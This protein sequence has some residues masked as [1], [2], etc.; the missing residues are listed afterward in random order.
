MPL[1]QK[2]DPGGW[3]TNPTPPATGVV[4]PPV[5]TARNE[6][7]RAPAVAATGNP[8]MEYSRVALI[9]MS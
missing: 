1:V 7:L 3:M 2:R 9:G 4:G 8:A 6:P 5:L